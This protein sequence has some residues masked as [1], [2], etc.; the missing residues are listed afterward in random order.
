LPLPARV[1]CHAIAASLA[2]APAGQG[3]LAPVDGPDFPPPRLRGDGLVP[4]ASALG[5]HRDP[6]HRLQFAH[7]NLAIA[8]GVG[9]IGLLGSPAV[10]QQLRRWLG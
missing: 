1:S 4:V 9:H 2:R 10:G 3:A 6:R 5:R 8:W 7:G